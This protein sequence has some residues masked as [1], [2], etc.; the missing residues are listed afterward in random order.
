M[1]E[2]VLTPMDKFFFDL[3]AKKLALR[4]VT[5]ISASGDSGASNARGINT[6]GYNP[7]FPASSIYVT[8]IGATQGT[9]VRLKQVVMCVII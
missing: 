3:E 1:C 7:I 8:A 5:I 6:C 2:C 4:G 9:E